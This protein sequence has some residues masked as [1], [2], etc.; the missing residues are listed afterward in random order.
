MRLPD[1]YGFTAYSLYLQA[2]PQ[3]K[4]FAKRIS[5]YA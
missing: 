5:V 1:C 2:V 4:S 3:M